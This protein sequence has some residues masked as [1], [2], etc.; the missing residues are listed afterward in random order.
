MFRSFRLLN[1]IV[2]VDLR[3]RRW[4][5]TQLKLR[6]KARQ[7]QKRRQEQHR[8]DKSDVSLPEPQISSGASAENDEDWLEISEDDF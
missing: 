6:E 2:Y 5:A 7:R 1:F 3:V 8:T 4:I